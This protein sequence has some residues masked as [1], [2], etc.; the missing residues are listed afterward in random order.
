V[1]P[2]TIVLL[3]SPNVAKYDLSTV[4]TV[5]CGA[6][7]LSTELLNAFIA[8]VFPSAVVV[9]GYGMTETTP[10]IVTF[11]REL[12]KGHEG[13][14][15]RLMPSYQARLVEEDG[16]DA[17]QGGPGE[18]WVRGP[19]VMKGYHDNVE[20]TLNTIAPGG[21]L[22]T[23]DIISI[24]PEGWF[25]VVDRK[26][27]LIKYKGFQVAPAELEG[28]LIQHPRVLDAGVVGVNDDSQ[29]TELPRA[30]IVAA[31]NASTPADLAAEVAAW[32]ASKAA[33]HKHLRGGI[34][35]VDVI[36]KSPSGKILRKNL[37]IR[38]QE[39]KDVVHR[40]TRAKL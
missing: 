1:P 4:T 34:V 24:N 9:Q 28:L 36:P 7:P 17:P 33:S 40:S 13:Y 20:A 19:S 31:D 35:V 37:R 16:T 10:N 38:A 22:K 6:A 23:G 2:I 29:A 30:Y 3:N 25:S 32:V 18:L 12:A 15:G 27:E 21:W 14:V 39:D 8:R 5:M 11:P 26:K